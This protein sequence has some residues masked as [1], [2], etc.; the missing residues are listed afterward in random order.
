M[1]TCPTCNGKGKI[2][3]M[4]R[5]IFG[6]IEM[7]KVGMLEAPEETPSPAWQHWLGPLP[8]EWVIQRSIINCNWMKRARMQHLISLIR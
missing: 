8:L 6:S 3:E 4:K 7:T 2:R 5:S 1:I